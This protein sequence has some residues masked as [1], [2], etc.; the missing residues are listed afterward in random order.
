[1]KYN[2]RDSCS[3][4]FGTPGNPEKTHFFRA[5]ASSRGNFSYQ[6]RA[7]GKYL[8][9]LYGTLSFL[10]LTFAFLLLPFSS[11]PCF[12]LPAPRSIFPYCFQDVSMEA[13][14]TNHYNILPMETPGLATPCVSMCFHGG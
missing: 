11:A 2:V 6:S 4:P 12:P 8:R 7:H 9:G 14:K 3:R 13:E 5:F 1:M 10:L